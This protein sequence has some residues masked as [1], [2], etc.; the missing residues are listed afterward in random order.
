MSLLLF[1]FLKC[2]LILKASVTVPNLP[3]LLGLMVVTI[4]LNC[5]ELQS[6]CAIYE[7]NFEG[8]LDIFQ[9]PVL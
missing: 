8:L 3:C 7:V 6:V 1:F 2:I 5:S 9:K 4:R